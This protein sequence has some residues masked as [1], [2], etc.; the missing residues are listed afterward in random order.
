MLPYGLQ[1]RSSR[2]NSFSFYLVK[3]ADNGYV[4]IGNS[5]TYIRYFQVIAT[6]DDFE[7]YPAGYSRNA[8]DEQ[9]YAFSISKD[10]D[11]SQ[12]FD[13][14]GFP[15]TELFLFP[16]YIK[17]TNGNDADEVMSGTTW[18]TNGVPVKFL[19]PSNSTLYL[20]YGDFV[21]T[22][23]GNLI[24][25]LVIWNKGEFRQTQASSQMFYIKTEC[26][27]SSDDSIGIIWKYNPF[28]PLRL[29]YFANELNVVNSGS[30]SYDDLTSIPDYATLI[31]DKGNYA[32]RD[33][34]PQGYT[35]TLNEIGVDYPFINGK[36]YLFA[37]V[38]LS[39]VPDL[40]DNATK[41]I[42]DKIWFTRSATNLNISMRTS[43][44]LKNVG[45]PCG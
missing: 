25:D 1:I 3:P 27:G 9:I 8:Y 40:T 15:L 21:K 11:V 43:D 5:D 39:V 29:R 45:K 38:V 14:F 41:N 26:M 37:P 36:R 44:D 16:C 22:V 13:N 42:F 34:L 28:V 7:I 17:K 2:V 31:D 24:G 12:Y 19:F 20:N 18:N 23:N 33:I 35:D 10:F 4:K 32:W 6:P 30:T